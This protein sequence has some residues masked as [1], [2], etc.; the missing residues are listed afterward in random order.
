MVSVGG[1]VTKSSVNSS[2]DGDGAPVRGC[3]LQVVADVLLGGVVG[4]RNT[5]ELNHQS[6]PHLT[7]GQE[8]R[9]PQVSHL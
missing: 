4:G 5:S 1:R 2:V 9:C 6:L 7:E 3:V 8:V